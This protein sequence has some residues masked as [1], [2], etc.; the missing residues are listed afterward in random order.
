MERRQLLSTF[1][2]TDTNDDA[3]PNSLRWAIIQANASGAASGAA[4]DFDIAD[5]GAVAIHLTA[6]LP[7]IDVPVV[8]DGTTEPGYLGSPLVEID[9]SGL[10]GAGIDGLS[11]TAGGSTVR[12]LSLVGFSDSGLMLTSGGDNEVAANYLGLTPAGAVL[13]NGCG[14]ALVGSS[15][16]TVGVGTTG[17]GNV[18]SG[19]TGDG[20]LIEPG[21]GIDS[22]SNTIVGNDI[23]TSPD[24]LHVIANAGA[25]IDVAGASTNVIGGPGPVFGNVVSGNQGAGIVVTGVRSGTTIEGNL[26]GVAAD[27]KTPLGNRGDGIHLDDAPGTTIGGSEF[28][29]GNIIGANQANGIET[30]GDTTGLQVLGNDV[31]TDLSGRLNLGNQQDGICLGSSANSIGGTV[32][33]ATNVIAF[34][35]AGRVGAAI[36][37]LGKVD[38]DTI[39]SNSIYGNAGLGINFGSGP[40]PNHAP[41]TPG[42]NDYQNYP[43]LSVAQNDG[44]A[45]TVQGSLYE[46]PNTSYVIQFF[47]NQQPDPSGYG[48]GKLLIGSTTAQTDDKG[49]ATFSVDMPPSAAAGYYVSATATD[50]EGNTSEFAADVQVQGQINLVL[51]GSAAPNPVAAGSELTFTLLV[52]NEGTADAQGVTLSDTLPSGVSV[53]SVTPSQGY[54]VPQMGSGTILANL[55]TVKAGAS[56]SVTN[57]CGDRNRGGRH[58]HGRGLGL[59]PGQRP[60]PR[61]R[62]HHDLGHRRDIGRPLGRA[63]RVSIAGPRRRRS[64]LHHDGGQPGSADRLERRRLPRGRAG[65]AFVSASVST[66]S[67]SFADGQVV[68][69]LGNL[70]SGGQDVVTVVLQAAAAGSV[71]ETA[72][73]TSDSLDPNLSNNNATVTTVIDPAC[74]LDVHIAADTDV[75]ASGVGF[76]YTVTVTNNGP[77]DATS[78]TLAD[79]LPSGVSLVSDTSDSGVTPTVA[80]GV[81]TVAIDTL[82]AGATATLAL[83]VTTT[84]PAGSSLVDSATVQGA[85]ADPNTANNS[86]T[87]SLPVRG[88][89]DLSVTATADPASG[90]VGLP[91]TFTIDVTNNGPADEPDAVLSGALPSGAAVDSTSSTQGGDPPVNEGILTADLG[92]LAAGQTAAVTVV[93]TPGAADV[94]LMTAGFSVQGQDY[95]PVP[96]N[97]AAAIGVPVAATSDLAAAIVPSNAPAVAQLPWSYSVVVTNHGPSAATGVVATVPMPAGVS[98]VSASSSQGDS[99]TM[100]S[101]SLTAELGAIASGA[102]ATVTVDIEPMPAGG[103]TVPLTATV[104]GD[105]YDPDPANNRASLSFAVN[106]SVAVALAMTS[107]PQTVLSGQIVTFIASVANQGSTPATDVV[108]AMPSVNGLNCVSSTPSQGAMALV[109]GQFVAN[110]GN[111]PAGATASVALQELAT[112]AGDYTMTATVTE[113]EYNLD[114]PAAMASASADVVESPGILQ[115]GTSSVEVT[116]QAGMAVIPVVRLFGATGTVTVQFQTAAVNATPG[117]DFTP[118]SGTLTL[119]PGQWTGSIQVPVLDDPYTNHDQYVDVTLA[120]PTGGA[121]LGEMS[122]TLLHIQDVDPDLTPPRVT[123]LTWSG[124]SRDITSLML[125]FTAPLDPIYATDPADYR[126]SMQAGGQPIPIASISYD[127]T[128]FAVTLVPQAP[129]PSGQYAEIQVVGVGPSAIRDLAGNGLD[130]VDN[131]VAGS[132]YSAFFG[133]GKRL[134]YQDASRNRVTLD[135]KGAGYLEQVLDSDGNCTV[136]T[137]AGMVPHRT[138]LQGRIKRLK[139]G[140]GQ[141]LIGTIN[142][143]GQFGDVKVLLKTPPFR[144]AQLPFQRRGR[145]VL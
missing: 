7:A 108:V 30:A 128:T 95:D 59:K 130:G 70:A 66:G 28:G 135:V 132:D 69:A 42:P 76:D 107:T 124:S 142:G 4:I 134:K 90:Y 61:R 125:T 96:L 85:E 121:T 51:T 29:D 84:A 80:N 45:T 15:G 38:Q 139:G 140:S 57:R 2:V 21:A 14:I 17:V 23:G 105:Q 68:A 13:A 126:L 18:I 52:T 100:Q 24:G 47:A 123:G 82:P 44:T 145:Y 75:A 116:D 22:A 1:V 9:G 58:D 33:G 11:L 62:I 8:I 94:G 143:L 43:V 122:A 110:L 5:S 131:G 10:T 136:L 67:T 65:L 19:N 37:L 102:S 103:G 16:N 120:N 97:N 55:G 77:S 26:I 98:F 31:G 73:V 127:P 54:I 137:V 63:G 141:T 112:A 93:V 64:D 56:A 91:I 113:D 46:T 104:A 118:V 12:G 35:G 74:D 144:V 50:P 83:A 20:V 25:G 60:R 89:S 39:L 36:Q 6:P 34:N 49:N 79:T 138:T 101:G 111:L 106:P 109:S 78:I 41:G 48:Q 92:S 71:T 40:T 99:P 3:N 115:F 133:Q 32:A 119:G 129:I 88:V 72:A 53:V 114:Q 86:A 27:G 117:R 87:L 81:V